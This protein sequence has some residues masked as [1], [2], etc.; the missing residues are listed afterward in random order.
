MHNGL[1]DKYVIKDNKKLQM[2]YTTGSCAAGA[3]KA[4]T[5]M[6][7]TGNDV[8]SVE[9]MTPKGIL[10]T[11][12]IKEKSK[13]EGFVSC[14]VE[15]FAGDDPDVTDKALVYAK[16]SK[17]NEAGGSNK[18]NIDGGLGVGRVTK[19][20]LDQP[21][22][23]AAINHVPREMITAAVKDIC[24]T[25]EYFG[26]IDVEISIPAGVELARKT[27][28]PR[29]GIE[30][31]ISV[32]GTSG[33]VMP[34][35][36]D[37]LIAS[38]KIEM[39]MKREGGAEYLL[40]TPGNYGTNYLTTALPFESKKAVKC[41][42]YIGNTI[43]MAIELGTKGILFVG[44][45]GKFVK[46]AGGIMNT[47][48]H[49]ADCR[50]EIIVTNA[51]MA[52]VPREVLTEITKCVTTDDAVKLLKESGYLEATMDRIMERMLFYVNQRAYNELKIGI[53]TF[54]NV[55]GELGK[56]GAVDELIELI[57]KKTKEEQL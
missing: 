37:A 42:N 35:S 19:P 31:G 53:I 15:K 5:I 8:R 11:L 57:A 50:M 22:G 36:E 14:A 10:L 43:D 25:F 32:L 6:L 51:M 26:D 40:I 30:G 9:L 24:E 17:T 16:V 1:E 27:F 38:I 56:A 20:G 23:N 47:H 18:V 48:S 33:I 39:S 4:A 54:S 29:L 46:L 44:H 7:L 41:S 2:G 45:F 3:A 49:N 12:E 34:M 13:G 52:G 28:N 55:Y 21:V